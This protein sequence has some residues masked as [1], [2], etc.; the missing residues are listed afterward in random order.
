MIL[1]PVSGLPAEPVEVLVCFRNGEA[2]DLSGQ[3]LDALERDLAKAIVIVSSASLAG[4][5]PEDAPVI[6]ADPTWEPTAL[7]RLTEVALIVAREREGRVRAEDRLGELAQAQDSF[8]AIVSHDL[9]TPVTTLRL[10]RDLFTS[11]LNAKADLLTK[12]ERVSTDELL[13]IMSRSLDRM[14]AFIDDMLEAWRLSP[15][16]SEQAPEPVGLNRVVGEV[17]AGLFPVAMQKDIVLDL[18]TDPDVGLVLAEAR[19]VGQVV[20]NLVGNALKFTPQ[21]G[22]VTVTTRPASPEDGGD[23]PGGAVLEVADT[24]PGIAAEDREKIF[25]RFSRGRA[26]ATGGEPSTGLGLYICRE[27]VE[28]YGGRIWFESAPGKGS[29]FFVLFLGADATES[30]RT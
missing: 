1:N 5:L 16:P 27:V 30:G 3:C 21:G 9:R 29:R 28:L 20:S 17:V 8:G 15:G 19:R 14:E 22:S 11:Q 4:S 23:L 26:R 10:L 2:R 6:T 12:N 13:G 18:A 24:G 7:A 25:R